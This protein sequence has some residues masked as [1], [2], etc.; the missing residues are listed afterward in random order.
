MPIILSTGYDKS[1]TKDEA[2]THGIRK[3]ALKPV[4]QRMPAALIR[5]VLD[6]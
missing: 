6:E 3:F 5:K 1:M 4:N 2:Q